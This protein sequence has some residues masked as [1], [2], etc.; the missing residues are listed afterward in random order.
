MRLAKVL[1]SKNPDRVPHLHRDDWGH[2]SSYE[3]TVK[4]YEFVLGAVLK[5]SK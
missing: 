3:D 2:T 4:V 1:K 5:P